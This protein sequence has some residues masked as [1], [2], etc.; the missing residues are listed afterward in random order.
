MEEPGD[1]GMQKVGTISQVYPLAPL[2]PGLFVSLSP[3][4]GASVAR[5]RL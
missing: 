3:C 5:S 4:L 2:S 1:K